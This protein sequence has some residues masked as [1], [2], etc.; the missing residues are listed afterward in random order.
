MASAME[1]NESVR[2]MSYRRMHTPRE[3]DDSDE[4]QLLRKTES[5]RAVNSAGRSDSPSMAAQS[6][7]PLLSVEDQL[8]KEVLESQRIDWT[9][10]AEDCRHIWVDTDASKAV[11]YINESDFCSSSKSSSKRYKVKCAACK[12]VVHATC[13]RQ[14]VKLGYTCRHTFKDANTKGRDATKHH[15]VNQRRL[16]GKCRQCGKGFSTNFL[17][18]DF[19]GVS[20]SW[21]KCSYHN[22]CFNMSLVEELCTLGIHEALI[23]PPA[24]IVKPARKISHVPPTK[25]SQKKK[26][27]KPSWKRANSKRSTDEKKSPFVIRPITI[28]HHTPIVVF[29]N[30][31]SGD[32]QGSK[33]MHKFQWLLNPR[34][35]FDLSLGGPMEGL[36]L[37]SSLPGARIMAC[38][39]DGTVGWVLSEL[40][41]LRIRPPPP[42]AVLPLGTGNDLSRSLNWGAA[43]T[44]EPMDKILQSVRTGQVVILDRWHLQ[45]VTSPDINTDN[46][47]ELQGVVKPPLDVIN[48]YFSIGADAHVTLEFHGAR[49]ANPEKF[50]QRWRNK[51]YYLS[52]GSQQLLQQKFKDLHRHIKLVCDGRD[53]T[54]RLQEHRVIAL[55]LLNIS[56]YASGTTPWGSPPDDSP[57]RQQSTDDKILEVFALTAGT[58]AGLYVGGHGI[59]IA[60]CSKVELTTRRS[61][62]I[63][64]DGE[65]CRLLPSLITVTLQNQVY[66][67]RRVKR[68]GLT[69]AGPTSYTPQPAMVKVA[70]RKIT[71]EQYES[72]HDLD[73]V[74]DM[75]TPLGMLYVSAHCDLSDIRLSLDKYCQPSDNESKRL[76]EKWCFLDVHLS[77]DTEKLFRVDMAEEKSLSIADIHHEGIYILELDDSFRKRVQTLQMTSGARRSSS[78]KIQRVAHGTAV[79]FY[80]RKMPSKE[81]SVEVSRADDVLDLNDIQLPD[82]MDTPEESDVYEDEPD[83]KVDL[84][85]RPTEIR[86]QLPPSFGFS[87]EE[88][89]LPSVVGVSNIL[90]NGTKAA[91]SPLSPD[92]KD[93]IEIRKAKAL[94]DAAKRGD[95]ERM[96]A[97]NEMGLALTVRGKE[98]LSPLHHAARHNRRETVRW[99]TQMLPREALDLVDDHRLQTALHKAAWY[100]YRTVCKHLVE[101]G[102]SLL[103]KDYQGNTPYNR[104]LEGTD[105]ELQAYLAAAEKRQVIA[106]DDQETAV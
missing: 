36:R 95:T 32:N 52:A 82:L 86:L 16:Q 19:I 75:A 38:G 42:V 44:D 33:L 65:P 46:V 21:C 60:Q 11:C 58:L 45:V 63:Q 59:R 71:L 61:L 80:R 28:A 88:H 81:G 26:K 87:H 14:A 69:S 76:F 104:S 49:E 22:Q 96:Q 78:P 106:Q 47:E 13:I 57:F 15:W 55:V 84:L 103:R 7:A 41:K 50:T 73:V 31:K 67:V 77:G 85:R 39:G 5:Y 30:P 98:G 10:H 35:V 100:G 48:N 34:Q 68:Q 92:E 9:D 72:H 99:L 102:A 40:D 89:P 29:I 83:P 43:Y 101:A 56:K 27:R 17:S 105:R 97:L 53:M 8:K 74:R 62:P 24:W 90:A 20:C 94:L 64:I 2:G 70:V 79:S 54:P 25:S 4:V 91:D 12:V 93:V 23:V 3:D 6:K 66:M 1:E 51:M 37:F 18:K